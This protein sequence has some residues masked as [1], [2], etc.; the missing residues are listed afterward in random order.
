MTKKNMDQNIRKGQNKPKGKSEK[1][2]IKI[3]I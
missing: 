2:E 3:K 1:W